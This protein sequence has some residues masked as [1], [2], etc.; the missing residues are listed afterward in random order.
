MKP[1]TTTREDLIERLAR[2]EPSR[3]AREIYLRADDATLRRNVER[4]EARAADVA[5]HGHI[6]STGIGFTRVES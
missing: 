4:M 3:K 6:H 2:V 1:E 5:R